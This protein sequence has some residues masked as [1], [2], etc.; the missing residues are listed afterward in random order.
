MQLTPAI[1]IEHPPSAPRVGQACC[2]N[3]PSRRGAS[4]LS[5]RDCRAPK[6]PSPRELV[7]TADAGE[8]LRHRCD[9]EEE[10]MS[11]LAARFVYA[12]LLST[13]F[14]VVCLFGVLGLAL[15]AVIIPMIAPE[16]LT[17]VL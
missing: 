15:S 7:H 4:N 9:T 3:G 12:P 6:S 10:P 5:G 16:Y 8:A 2:A 17:W 1:F 14:K 11:D 13:S